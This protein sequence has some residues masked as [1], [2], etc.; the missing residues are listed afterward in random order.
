MAAELIIKISDMLVLQTSSGLV[1]ITIHIWQAIMV[2]IVDLE[3]SLQAVCV[4]GNQMFMI[5]TEL[6]GNFS[7]LVSSILQFKLLLELR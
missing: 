6:E 2:L 5:T 7:D 4:T 1:G 3:A